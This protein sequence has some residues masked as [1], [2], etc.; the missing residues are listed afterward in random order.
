MNWQILLAINLFAASI[1]EYLNKKVSDKVP[2]TVGLFY[3]ILFTQIFLFLY[4]IF[5]YHRIP[6]FS[7]SLALPG[8]I[9]F[10][11]FI[12]Y[13][14]ALKISLSQSILF[15]SYSTLVTV[16]L[17]AIFLGESQYFDLRTMT[18]LK[19]AGGIILSCIALWYLLNQK[20]KK[21][22]KLEKKWFFYIGGTILFLGIGSFLTISSI[23]A[24]APVEVL[25]NQINLMIPLYLTYAILK[26][27]KLLIGK[28][29]YVTT[30]LNGLVS[31]IAVIAFYEALL[32]TPVAKFYPLQQLSLVILTMFTGV[33]FFKEKDSFSKSKLV[34]MIL[35]FLGMV[36]LVTS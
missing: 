27:D 24:Y 7:I 5:I 2:P 15:Q 31:A 26:K 28:K 23:H 4:F 35:G 14:T 21:Q 32:I 29:M 9:F 34:G 3:I 8:V 33:I 17:S 13:F 36:L 25:I 10:L 19:I 16:F 20:N 6:T 12:Y 1:R 30:L 11:G 22:V 18:G